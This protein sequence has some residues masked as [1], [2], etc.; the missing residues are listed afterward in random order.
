[1]AV[2]NCSSLGRAT[3]MVNLHQFIMDHDRFRKMEVDEL[4]FVE[5]T[6]MAEETRL[7]IWSHHNYFAYIT[8]GKKMWKSKYHDYEVQQGDLLFIKKGAHLTHQFFEDEFCAI[9]LFL[10]DAFIQSFLQKHSQFLLASPVLHQDAILRVTRD[11]L[12]ESYFVSI[13]SYLS[14][15]EKP[16]EALLKLK[17]EELLLHLCTS[18]RHQEMKDYFVSL[19]DSRSHQLRAVMEANFAYHLQVE[20]Y[21][22]LC[23]Q[24]LSSF[25][26]SFQQLYHT[27]PAAWLRQRRLDLAL[28]LL[29]TSDLAIGQ[30]SFQCGFEDASHFIRVFKQ[31]HGATPHQYRLS[32]V[33]QGAGK[34]EEG[35]AR[36]R[37]TAD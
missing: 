25:K 33:R 23:H 30:I 1:M 27:T 31:Q 24:S 9:F 6:C 14:L 26:R 22:K 8:S 17:F 11:E 2:G 28:Q 13:G 3:A 20:D 15:S 34:E 29:I 36:S 16:H 32:H 21:A 4:L 7:G 19:C 37:S 18:A 35:F 10:P 5:Y 12:L